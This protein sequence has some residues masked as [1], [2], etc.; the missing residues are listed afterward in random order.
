MIMIKRYLYAITLIHFALL[1]AVLNGST[2]PLSPT[3]IHTIANLKALHG[4]LYGAGAITTTSTLS[5][6][7]GKILLQKS[8]GDMAD[9]GGAIAAVG[10]G[11][12]SAFTLAPYAAYKGG[13][14]PGLIA[15]GTS[16]ALI[17]GTQYYL[18][19]KQHG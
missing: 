7:C 11:T 5:F 1:P 9:L 18:D 10:L 13:K 3:L 4:L 2:P 16:L 8:M 12:I 19:E 15:Y 6:A 14:L 17:I